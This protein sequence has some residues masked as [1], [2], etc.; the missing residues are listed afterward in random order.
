MLFLELDETEGL[1][2]LQQLYQTMSDFFTQKGV[3]LPV[4]M[5][6]DQYAP[7]KPH[8][9]IAKTSKVKFQRRRGRP[10]NAKIPYTSY[11]EFKD[12]ALPEEHT[13]DQIQLCKMEGKVSVK[14]TPLMCE[15]RTKSR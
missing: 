15:I 1:S 12:V 4:E 11:A 13:I 14:S 2:I 3:L 5:R 6:S 8:L 10:R 9:T 7:Y